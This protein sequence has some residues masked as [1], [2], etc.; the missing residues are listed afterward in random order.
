MNWKEDR[1]RPH[2][3]RFLSLTAV[4]ALA[5]MVAACSSS[6][7]GTSGTTGSSN[8]SPIMIGASLSL[9]GDNSV[10][11][12]AFQRGYLLWQNYINSHGGLDGGRKVQTVSLNDPSAPTTVAPNSTKLISQDRLDLTFGPSS[13]LLTGPAAKVAARY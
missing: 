12:Q 13:T 1:M 2:H 4:T 6:G 8:K 5:A 9:T 10:D 3:T 7:S 11:G